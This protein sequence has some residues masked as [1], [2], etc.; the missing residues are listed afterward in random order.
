MCKVLGIGLDLC[1]ISRMERLLGDQRFLT[2]CFT[3]AEQAYLQ[4]RG[5]MASASMAAMWA[6]KEAAGKALGTGIAFPMTDVEVLHDESGAPTYALHGEALARS[7]GGRL[8]LSIS[9]EGDMAAAV[10]IWTE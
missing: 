6:A 10:C 5:L 9:H 3:A 2:R 7:R 4:G 1:A 8:L